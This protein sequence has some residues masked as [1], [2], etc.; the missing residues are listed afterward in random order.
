[1]V[2]NKQA[3]LLVLLGCAALSVQAQG[4][5]PGLWEM[6]QKPQ[7]DPAQQAKMEQ[8]QKAMANMPAE[9]RQMMEKMMG[10]RG[11]QMGMANGVI[12]IKTC[13]SKEQAEKHEM[14]VQDQGRC[15]HEVKRDGKTVRTHFVCTDPASEGDGEFTFD[16]PEHYTSK[17]AIKRGDKAMSMSGE[18]RWLGSDCGDIKPAAT[19][20]H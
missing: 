6:S 18:A 4:M 8:A 12:S 14:P 13:I 17:L 10:Q 19:H 2:S 11:M 16:S 1:M 7:L 3:F 5:K 15:K 20:K 9:Q